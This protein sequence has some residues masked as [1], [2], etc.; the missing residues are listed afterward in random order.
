[1]PVALMMAES[2]DETML[3][4]SPLAEPPRVPVLDELAADEVAVAVDPPSPP[5]FADD[6]LEVRGLQERLSARLLPSLRRASRL[7]TPPAPLT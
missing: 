1:M 2:A 4:P 3:P 6:G 7:W 5:E